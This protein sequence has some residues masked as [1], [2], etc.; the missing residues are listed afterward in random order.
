MSERIY[1]PDK[2]VIIEITN[3]KGESHRRV[4]GSW[5]GGFAGSNS[6]RA[7]SGITEVIDEGDHYRVL[8]ESGSTYNCFKGCE[9]MSSYTMGILSRMQEDAKEDGAKVEQVEIVNA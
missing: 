3:N 9:G 6:W 1:A 2:W 4:L 7:S 8:N 5:Y